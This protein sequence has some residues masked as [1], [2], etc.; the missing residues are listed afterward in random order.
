MVKFMRK[1]EEFFDHFQQVALTESEYTIVANGGFIPNKKIVQGVPILAMYKFQCVGVLELFS[2][3]AQGGSAIQQLKFS[4]K[5][6]I[7]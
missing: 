5:F 7:V 4:K 2:S 3:R 1:P 6:N